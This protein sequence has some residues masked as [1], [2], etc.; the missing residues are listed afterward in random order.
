MICILICWSF[1]IH[2][3]SKYFFSNLLLLYFSKTFN[4]VFI[5]TIFFWN[6]HF[7]GLHNICHGP[8]VGWKKNFQTLKYFRQEWVYWEQRAE[9]VRGAANTVGWLSDRPGRADPLCGL[10]VNFYSLKTKKIPAGRMA[11]G[12]WSGCYVV[13][14]WW[15][16]YLIC[17]RGLSRLGQESPWQ[18]LL[19]GLS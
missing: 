16:F 14:T 8:S 7:M 11:L 15:I 18:Q 12:D 9:L 19:W 2:T 5:E 13:A 6:L 1:L 17:T 10:V 3:S 4:L